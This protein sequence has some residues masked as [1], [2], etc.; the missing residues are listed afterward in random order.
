M[1]EVDDSNYDY[2]SKL[3]KIVLN[4][5]MMM[6]NAVKIFIMMIKI[7]IFREKKLRNCDFKC[8]IRFRKNVIFRFMFPILVILYVYL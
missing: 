7:M 8:I 5:T 4:C 3:N 1:L 6:M 2:Q